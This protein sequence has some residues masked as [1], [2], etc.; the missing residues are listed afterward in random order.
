MSLDKKIKANKGALFLTGFLV[1]LAGIVMILIW[2]TDVVVFF[3]GVV[4]M[5]VALGGLL[6][7]YMVK[8]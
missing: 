3:K 4:G 2:W 5:A 7:L 1:L 6:L 8:E